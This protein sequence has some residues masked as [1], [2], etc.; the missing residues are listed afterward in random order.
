MIV[1]RVELWPGGDP[2]MAENLGVLAIANEGPNQDPRGS[3]ADLY[4]Y[5]VQLDTRDPK[6]VRRHVVHFRRHGWEKLVA[7]AFGAVAR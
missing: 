3:D 4:R 7:T 5:E 6:H 1:V 2:A